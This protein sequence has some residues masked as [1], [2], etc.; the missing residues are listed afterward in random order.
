VPKQTRD[1]AH[2]RRE[3][4]FRRGGR[5]GANGLSESPVCQAVELT[6]AFVAKRKPA[7][8]L[9]DTPRCWLA[10]GGS[11][12]SDP[13]CRGRLA[14]KR[15]SRRQRRWRLPSRDSAS[16]VGR[17]LPRHAPTQSSGPSQPRSASA[18]RPEHQRRRGGRVLLRR[19][20]Q[21][22]VPRALAEVPFVRRFGG[23]QPRP[24]GQ[25]PSAECTSRRLALQLDVGSAFAA[26]SATREAARLNAATAGRPMLTVAAP[27]CFRLNSA[28]SSHPC[29]IGAPSVVGLVSGYSFEAGARSA[30]GRDLRITSLTYAFMAAIN[31]PQAS[32]PRSGTGSVAPN[33]IA[34]GGVRPVIPQP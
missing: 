6:L 26:V 30:A 19:A 24:C 2:L 1:S 8:P 4:W 20:G 21:A 15:L 10:C 13:I 16:K 22:V 9:A 11:A 14:A 18:S 5:R 33:L 27:S 32:V 17:V 28:R 31:G 7:P 23:S 29:H 34:G 12:N 3:P 25:N